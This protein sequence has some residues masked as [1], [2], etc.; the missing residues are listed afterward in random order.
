[1]KTDSNAAP[2]SDAVSDPAAPDPAAPDPAAKD[3][4]TSDDIKNNLEECSICWEMVKC[5]EED[6]SSLISCCHRLTHHKKCIEN[7]QKNGDK[8]NYVHCVVDP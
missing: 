1:M 4:A 3:D 5:Y 8:N 6:A 2:V 7:M